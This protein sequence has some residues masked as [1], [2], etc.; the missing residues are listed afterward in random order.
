MLNTLKKELLSK[1]F[2]EIKKDESIYLLDE[3]LKRNKDILFLNIEYGFYKGIELRINNHY[4]VRFNF[5]KD[6]N[7]LYPRIEVYKYRSCTKKDI[8]LNIKLKAFN[9]DDEFEDS[10]MFSSEK[11][12]LKDVAIYGDKMINVYANDFKKIILLILKNNNEKVI[13][14]NNQKDEEEKTRKNN[15]DKI[16]EYEEEEINLWY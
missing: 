2:K 9:F 11:I 15:L 3:N 5:S 1:I 10:I 13:E 12:N 16:F 6:T 4:A 8:L 14:L 7:Y